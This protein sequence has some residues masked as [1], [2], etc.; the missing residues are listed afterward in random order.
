MED[1]IFTENVED[2]MHLLLANHFPESYSTAKG[3]SILPGTP[4]V[5]RRGESDKNLWWL[6]FLKSYSAPNYF[7]HVQFSALLLDAEE[8]AT[9]GP[10]SL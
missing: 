3:N 10:Q 6:H 9:K 8:K 1:R 4:A 5:D 2:R 7:S